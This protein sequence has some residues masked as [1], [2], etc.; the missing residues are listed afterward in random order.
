MD[1]TKEINVTK[2][3]DPEKIYKGEPNPTKI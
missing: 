1:L 2:S 3:F